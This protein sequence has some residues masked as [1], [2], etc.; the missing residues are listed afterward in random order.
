MAGL[1]HSFPHVLDGVLA[2]SAAS[3]HVL[4]LVAGRTRDARRTDRC[5]V[6]QGAEDLPE[7]HS[8]HDRRRNGE[9]DGGGRRTHTGVQQPLVGCVE[10]PTHRHH[11]ARAPVPHARAH[12]VRRTRVHDT[13]H[14]SQCWHGFVPAEIPCARTENLR[15]LT[16]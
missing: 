4:Y 1:L 16:I 12:S 9:P 8:A 7:R 13:R 11:R 5:S 10:W 15:N 14:G 2:E 6:P 3:A